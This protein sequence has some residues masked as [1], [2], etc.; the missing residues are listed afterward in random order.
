MSHNQ[1]T[2]RETLLEG[3]GAGFTGWLSSPPR[4]LACPKISPALAGSHAC[5]G[6]EECESFPASADV[7]SP[8]RGEPRSQSE[9]AAQLSSRGAP[10]IAPISSVVD[11]NTFSF[12][13]LSRD[14]FDESVSMKG[15]REGR[16]KNCVQET[17]KW[18]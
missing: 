18:E 14:S 11:G 8:R 2:S 7:A 10:Q 6:V 16:M 5:D 13:Y 17:K 3:R 12:F 4:R 1:R 9:R 15:M